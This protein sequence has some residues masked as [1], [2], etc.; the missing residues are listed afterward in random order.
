V[1]FQQRVRNESANITAGELQQEGGEDEFKSTLLIALISGIIAIVVLVASTVTCWYQKHQQDA[2]R[3]PQKLLRAKID[4]WSTFDDNLIAKTS[5]LHPSFVH[6]LGLGGFQ[7]HQMSL[8]KITH[9]EDVE[10]VSSLLHQLKRNKNLR[11]L[12]LMAQVR[13]K[14]GVTEAVGHD[15][16]TT[17]PYMTQSEDCVK[18]EI[19]MAWSSSISIIVGL[20]SLSAA[21]PPNASCDSMRDVS[22]VVEHAKGQ[23]RSSQVSTESNS[24]EYGLNA[25]SQVTGS[26]SDV[27]S[28]K[29]IEAA[30]RRDGNITNKV[31][32]FKS[33]MFKQSVSQLFPV[34]VPEAQSCIDA[35]SRDRAADSGADRRVLHGKPSK[36]AAGSRAHQIAL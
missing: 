31:D 8:L 3:Q 28:F 19:L 6:C 32:D 16:D 4:A 17:E 10:V 35:K 2:L 11:S 33:E 1:Y 15:G 5:S 25:P 7:S 20:T 29:S 24:R 34:E 14:Y 21:C 30:I 26:A 12:P 27:E 18:V 9:L 13:F 22:E 36:L 23:E